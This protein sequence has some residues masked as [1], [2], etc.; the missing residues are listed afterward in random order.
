MEEPA[1]GGG[2]A[3]AV[4]ATGEEAPAAGDPEAVRA[5]LRAELRAVLDSAEELDLDR[6]FL[7]SGG[8][9]FISTLFITRVEERYEIGLT[10]DDLPLELPLADIFGRL[11][12]DIAARSEAAA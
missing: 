5:Y 2:P 9:S 12:D 7:E 4:G 11:A 8:D 1:L 6:S 10:A 3:A